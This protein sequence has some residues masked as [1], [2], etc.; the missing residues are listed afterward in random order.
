MLTLPV[1]AYEAIRADPKQFVVLPLQYT[2]KVEELVVQED[3]HWVVRKT[4]EAGQY[5]EQLDPRSRESQ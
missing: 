4:G 5:V 2:P 3:T 1:A